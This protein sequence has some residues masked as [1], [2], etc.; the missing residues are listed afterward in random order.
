[1]QYI[2]FILYE[3]FKPIIIIVMANVDQ[4]K[5]DYEKANDIYKRLQVEFGKRKT[6]EAAKQSTATVSIT[7]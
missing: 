6:A 2:V 3:F 1:M 5:A 7:L 4:F